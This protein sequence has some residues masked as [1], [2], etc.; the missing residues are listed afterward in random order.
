MSLP[1]VPS[2]CPSSKKKSP[3]WA[4]LRAL[5]TIGFLFLI[6]IGL[7]PGSACSLRVGGQE[8]V[9]PLGAAQV[10]ASGNWIPALLFG[11][12]GGLALIVLFGRS[13]CGWLCPGRWIFNRTPGARRKNWRAVRWIQGGLVGGVIG[14][15]A[16]CHTPLF[17]VI[18]P[19][20]VFCRGA[21]AMGSGGS[22]L[23]TV[24]WLSAALS[25]EWLSGRSWCRD[26]CPL[27]ASISRLSALNP[28]LH[29]KTDKDKCSPCQ[30]CSKA[31]SLG[32]N[33]A[34]QAE[35]ESCSKC[36]DC[37]EA[38]PR[39]ALGMQVIQLSERKEERNPAE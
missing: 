31:C 11:G 28:F 12:L 24:G 1:A 4:R 10:I 14:A 23:P 21:A 22:L 39:Q 25:V 6:F 33:P 18:C 19:A 7:L 13:F 9:C 15:A 38:C 2:R 26:L 29:I 27:G 3:R 8:I 30:M 35:M 32:L 34:T 17:C 36:L 16:L 5:V 20:G 37:L